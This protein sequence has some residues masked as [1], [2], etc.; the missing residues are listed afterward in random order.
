M[1]KSV[2]E[3]LMPVFFIAHGAPTLA[4]EQGPYVD[5]LTKL[6]KTIQKPEAIVIFSAHYESP[7]QLIGSVKQYETIY[8][9]YGFPK[10]LYE[11]TYPA[12]GHQ[13]LAQEIHELFKANNIKSALDDERG[14]DHGAW[15]VLKLMYPE[16]DIPVVTLSVDPDK[17]PQEHYNIGKAL[18]PLR[19]KGV[20]IIGSGNSVHNLRA[21]NWYDVNAPTDKW[22]LEFDDWIEKQ[23]KDWNVDE[24]LQYEKKAPHFRKAVPSCEHF[25][26]IILAAGAADGTR[27]VQPIHRSSQFGNLTYFPF[28][29]D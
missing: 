24:L 25:I 27:K 14:I 23:L 9:F 22:A 5:F 2:A 18:A 8:D 19:E 16:C 21:L 4:I 26:P 6:H 20:L 3:N 11:M 1:F 12:K 13:A 29:F 10:A 17:N 7:V 28:R 15:T